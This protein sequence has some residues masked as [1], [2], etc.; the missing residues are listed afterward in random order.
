MSGR[1]INRTLRDGIHETGHVPSPCGI[2]SAACAFAICSLWCAGAEAY[3]PG[4]V[5]TLILTASLPPAKNRP[6]ASCRA[7]PRESSR[8]WMRTRLAR[9]GLTSVENL[10]QVDPLQLRTAWGSVTGARLWYALHGYAVAP[11][12]TQRRSIGHG[13]VLPPGQRPSTPS[14]AAMDAP[15]SA[16]VSA[17]SPA[18][19]WA[20]RSPTGAFPN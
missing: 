17:A 4:A 2:S 19:T 13:R 18:A 11:P 5:C 9:W 6:I 15:S 8:S 20:P 12:R 10:W 3:H 16:T 7:G 1:P 14:T